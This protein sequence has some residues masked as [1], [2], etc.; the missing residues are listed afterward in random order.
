M[1]V[2]YAV[3]LS[4]IVHFTLALLLDKVAP[5]FETPIERT[6]EIELIETPKKDPADKSKERQIVRSALAPEQDLKEDDEDL[7]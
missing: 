5:Y 3:L 1:R 6:A 2:F 7:A 4:L